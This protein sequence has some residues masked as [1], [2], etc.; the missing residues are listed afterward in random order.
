MEPEVLI[1]GALGLVIAVL[2]ALYIRERRLVNKAVKIVE[3]KNDHIALIE[4]QSTKEYNQLD[5]AF[6]ERML[7]FG[8]LNYTELFA[9]DDEIAGKIKELVNTERPAFQEKYLARKKAAEQAAQAEREAQ[10]KRYAEQR[11]KAAAK[12]EEEKKARKSSSGVSDSTFIAVP[13]VTDTSFTSISCDSSGG[14]GDC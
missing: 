10:Q 5:D 4:R 13:I 14:G 11:E 12:A 8:F 1:Y 6:H 7:S 3:R 2:L 9:Q